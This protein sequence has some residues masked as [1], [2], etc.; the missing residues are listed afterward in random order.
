MQS[1]MLKTIQHDE[2]QYHRI[3]ESLRI[4]AFNTTE[5]QVLQCCTVHLSREQKHL[6]G[7]SRVKLN[8]HTHKGEQHSSANLQTFLQF[9][10]LGVMQ[11]AVLFELLFL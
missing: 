8:T 9:I 10:F 6:L 7:P 1:N 5:K 11:H 2:Q 3:V 4:D